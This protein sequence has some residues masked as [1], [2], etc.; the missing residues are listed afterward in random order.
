M[1]VTSLT[2]PLAAAT[3]SA[4]VGTLRARG[5]RVSAARRLVL[6]ALYAAD[7][8]VTADAIAAGMDGRLPP[9]DLSSVYR[10]LETFEALGLVEHVHLGHGPGRYV[11]GGRHGALAL[12]D[13]CDTHVALEDGALD[14][15]RA[16]VLEA[17]GFD[18]T[19]SHFPIVGRCAACHAHS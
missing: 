17:T 18:A 13:A 10:N 19:F 12:C 9:S 6:E 15:V 3:P 14:R 11:L 4:A 7:A 1:T 8:P 2:R 5:L 16:A